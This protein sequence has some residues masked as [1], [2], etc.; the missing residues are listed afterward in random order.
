MSNSDAETPD[1]G[2]TDSDIVMMFAG[3]FV[4]PQ[5]DGFEVPCSGARVNLS[6]LVREM[7]TTT[8]L[9]LAS[10]DVI[11][12]TVGKKKHLF[13]EHQT[14]YVALNQEAV[15]PL[16]GL[17]GAVLKGLRLKASENSVRDVV[18]RV[19]GSTTIEPYSAIVEICMENAAGAGYFEEQARTGTAAFLGKR[20][21]PKLFQPR[22]ERIGGLAPQVEA[23]R[24]L[25]DDFKSEHPDLY[26]VLHEDIEKSVR[27]A[28]FRT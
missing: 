27:A 28:Y 1:K 10:R 26:E 13:S 16:P 4:E 8:F 21:L 2:T 20:T 19:V 15:G 17:E 12:L 5:E 23:V 14:V 24:R 18:S 25:R 11:G 3:D 9:S 22:C 7:L 6:A